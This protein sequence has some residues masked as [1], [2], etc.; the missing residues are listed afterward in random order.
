MKHQFSRFMSK[1]SFIFSLIL[2]VFMQAAAYAQTYPYFERVMRNNFWND[3]PNIAG[4]RMDTT[5]IAYAE[6][7]TDYE[8]GGFHAPWL[9]QN[10]WDI[11][12]TSAGIRHMDRISMKGSFSFE[13]REL[14]GAC[15]SMFISPGYYPVDVMEFTPGHKTHQTYVIDGGLSYAVKENVSIGAMVEFKSM[16]MAKRKDLRH[17]NKGLDLTFSPGIT[18]SE[19]GINVGICYVFNKNT[20]SISAQ[21]IGISD[22]SYHAFFDKGMMYGIYSPWNGSGVYLNEPGLNALPLKEIRN[23]VAAQLQYRDLFVNAECYSSKGTVGEKEYEWFHFPGSGIGVDVGYRYGR[24]TARLTFEWKDR[25]L[26]ESVIEKFSENGVIVVLNHGEN[27]ITSSRGWSLFPEYEYR[28]HEWEVRAVMELSGKSTT[29]HQIYPYA[30]HQALIGFGL[31]A[32]G[33]M[34]LDRWSIAG[35]DLI[36]FD[37][38]AG[39]LYKGGTVSEKNWLVSETSGAMTSPFRMQE[40]HDKQMEYLTASRIGL[41]VGLRYEFWKGMYAETDLSFLTA[42]GIDYLDGPVRFGASLMVGYNF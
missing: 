4:I 1:K 38:I 13:D 24:H 26:K 27:R 7:S 16:N 22:Q 39:F 41:K 2:L 35:F 21:Q 8:G 37:A 10:Q 28:N 42:M 33:M 29:T 19:D 32:E 31:E 23:G 20:E 3:S 5:S 9:S 36:G 6:L 25:V 15:G 14:Y 11:R 12:L 30:S 34:H 18:Y 40:W 17:E